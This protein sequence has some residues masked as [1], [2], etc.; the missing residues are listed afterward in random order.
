MDEQLELCILYKPLSVPF[1]RID[2]W[3]IMVKG[4]HPQV[5]SVM[6][7]GRENIVTKIECNDQLELTVLWLHHA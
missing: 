6:A 5:T 7:D 4:I 1:K 3:Q 2:E